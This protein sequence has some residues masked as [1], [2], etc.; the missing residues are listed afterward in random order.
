MWVLIWRHFDNV[1]W[2]LASNLGSWRKLAISDISRA[3][4][5]MWWFYSKLDTVF[6]ICLNLYR[7]PSLMFYGTRSTLTFSCFECVSSSP[8]I[9]FL[10]SC[11]DK[12]IH[13]GY[14]DR[15]WFGFNLAVVA[16]FCQLFAW[17]WNCCYVISLHWMIKYF[18]EVF[19]YTF[20]LTMC[21]LKF[22]MVLWYFSVFLSA[23]NLLVLL[24]CFS[25]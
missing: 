17:W 15:L 13:T 5:C 24:V 9:L 12:D 11:K 6:V 16:H 22:W 7:L 18:I 8:F 2:F 21:R 10:V 4:L 25:G 3:S 20:F 14:T 23:I 1:Y 19:W